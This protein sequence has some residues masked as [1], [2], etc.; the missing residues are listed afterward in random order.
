MGQ[1][2]VIP[3]DDQTNDAG[4][5]ATVKLQQN[6]KKLGYLDVPAYLELR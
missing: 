5:E 4:T 1:K 3:T 6:L 2:L